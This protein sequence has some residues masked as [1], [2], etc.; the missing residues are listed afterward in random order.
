LPTDFA[1]SS[2]EEERTMKFLI[3]ARPSLIQRDVS[4]G[5]ADE[6][7]EAMNR[8]VNV[9]SGF[10]EGAHNLADNSGTV[11]VVDAN[12]DAQVVDLLM[13]MPV[14]SGTEIEAH[15]VADSE[16]VGENVVEPVKKQGL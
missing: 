6:A 7:T 4:T 3:I 12:S 14:F 9:K 15:P 11:A 16:T 5:I 2:S 10:I 1:E 13:S 8:N